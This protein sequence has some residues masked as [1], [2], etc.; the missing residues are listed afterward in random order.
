M[1]MII[2]GRKTSSRDGK[3]I[4]VINPANNKKLDTIPM[5][6]EED[7][8]EAV[9]NAKEGQKEWAAIPLMDKE[10]LFKRSFGFLRNESVRLSRSAPGNAVN[11]WRRRFLNITRRYR[12]SPGILRRQ[13]GSTANFSCRALNRGMTAKQPKISLW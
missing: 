10:K 9:V 3:T 2:G 7:V 6:T 12:F 1:Q 5:A 11:M 13:S 8:N 4:D